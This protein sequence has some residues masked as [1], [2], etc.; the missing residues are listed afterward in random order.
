MPLASSGWRPG[1]PLTVLRCRGTGWPPLWTTAHPTV[2]SVAGEDPEQG[3]HSGRGERARRPGKEKA[4]APQ[5]TSPERWPYL[6]PQVWKVH[7][8]PLQA[9]QTPVF[10][11]QEDGSRA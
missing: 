2:S 4:L 7:S 10:L 11:A 3:P 9:V 6:H 5:V 8:S 1:T